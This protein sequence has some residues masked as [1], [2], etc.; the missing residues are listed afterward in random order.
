MKRSKYNARKTFGYDS[1]KEHK[2]ANELKML[3]KIGEIS[4]LREQVKYELIPRQT[5]TVEVQLKTKTKTKEVTI[6]H[7]CSYL[8]DFVYIQDGKTI[9]EDSKGMRLSDYIIKRKLML[10]LHGIRIKET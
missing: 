2:R 8:A 3:E 1:K 10:F 9:V 4:E 7:P 6:E 5:E